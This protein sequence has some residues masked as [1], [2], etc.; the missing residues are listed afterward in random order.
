M[1][2]EWAVADCLRSADQDKDKDKDKEQQD[3]HQDLG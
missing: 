2:G 1:E 3:L